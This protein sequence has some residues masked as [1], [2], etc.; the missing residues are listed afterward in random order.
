VLE[1]TPPSV[2]LFCACHSRFEPVGYV[3]DLRPAQVRT[4]VEVDGGGQ[5]LG[6][7]TEARRHT[8]ANGTDDV[9]GVRAFDRTFGIHDL[10]ERCLE[11]TG[12]VGAG[13]EMCVDSVGVTV[14]EFT[15]FSVAPQ[16]SVASTVHPGRE[17]MPAGPR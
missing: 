16:I 8:A 10:L 13:S 2:S 1:K 9:V 4:D 3:L 15:H 7:S 6:A 17:S 11:D 14:S 5:H 12:R